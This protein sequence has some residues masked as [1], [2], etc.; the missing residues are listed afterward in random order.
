[1][2]TD[3]RARAVE[4]AV[5]FLRS[6]AVVAV[7]ALGGWIAHGLHMPL[8]WL[9]GALASAA[10]AASLG[11]TGNLRGAR[12]CALVILG[13]GMGEDFTG[14][15]L[16]LLLENLPILALCG[17]ITMA[18]GLGVAGIFR[19]FAGV[20]SRTAFFCGIPGGITLMVTHAQEAG[21]S[22]AHVAMAQT[23]RLIVLVII[24]PF[25]ISAFVDAG[26]VAPVDVVAPAE[27][28]AGLAHLALWL[29]AGFAV[30]KICQK[31]RMP[32]PWLVAPCFLSIAFTSAGA[33]PHPMPWPL[34]V[35]AQVVLGASLGG[36]ITPRFLRG[37]GGLVFASILSAVVLIVILGAIGLALSRFTDF[38][39]GEGLLGMS[40]GGMPEMALTAHALGVSVPLVLGFHLVRIIMAIFLIEPLAWL[41][42]RL[43]LS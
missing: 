22:V 34:L 26:P 14:P 1:M 37:S 42:H 10:L 39:V 16:R 19:R 20:D 21:A 25:L 5:P 18:A 2:N 30:A 9:L 35:A 8:A 32:N 41:S 15:I 24:Y 12:L 3:T 36:Q 31:L 7:S 43:R 17:F 27:S 38:T 33:L 6:C 13:L 29:A 4:A 28:S 23:L 40:P 11:L